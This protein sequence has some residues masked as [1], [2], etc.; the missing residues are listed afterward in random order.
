MSTDTRAV[1]SVEPI[2]ES[3]EALAERD[4]VMEDDQLLERL[5]AASAH[6]V[7]LVPD[8]TGLTLSLLD[9][10]LVVTLVATDGPG[11]E[12]ARP[13][14][15]PGVG[16]VLDEE[17]WR[18]VSVT[19]AA[20]AVA[21]TLTLPLLA[22]ERVVGS[23]DLYAASAHAFTGRHEELAAVL[24]AWSPGAVTNADLSFAT[25]RLAQAAPQR[26]RDR[27]RFDTAT[28]L[29]AGRE[30]VSEEQAR[31]LLVSSSE[32]SGVRLSR[33]VDAVISYYAEGPS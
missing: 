22:H 30:H 9:D 19:T 10:G 18:T 1:R 11:A 5:V 4:A 26:L 21:S 32:R 13:E 15:P 29:V 28:G 25:R 33:I 17:R 20:T 31:D 7:A 23:V 6:V 27:A 14:Q 12:A 3:V 8:C 24:G 2:P 16:D